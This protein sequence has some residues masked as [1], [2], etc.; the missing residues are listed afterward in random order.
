MGG[1]ILLLGDFSVIFCNSS[2][3]WGM[4]HTYA[5]VDSTAGPGEFTGEKVEVGSVWG[6]GPRR[7]GGDRGGGSYGQSSLCTCM[8]SHRIHFLKN[9]IIKKLRS[10]G[11]PLCGADAGMGRLVLPSVNFGFFLKD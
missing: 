5:Q 2:M 10:K 4:P 8:N 7:V 6:V 9:K 11:A 3:L 1:I